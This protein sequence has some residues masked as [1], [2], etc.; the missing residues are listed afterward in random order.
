VQPTFGN[1]QDEAITEQAVELLNEKLSPISARA[2]SYSEAGADCIYPI[3][4]GDEPTIRI[5]RDRIKGPIN[6][7]ASP[8]TAPLSVLR[9][10]GINRVSFG[11]FLFRSLL[12][13]FVE[14]AEAVMAGADYSVFGEVMTDA[15]T[16]EF[17]RTETEPSL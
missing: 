3:G 1:L 12:R 16:S 2:K 14:I 6:I 13:K 15:Q 8:S 9:Q 4:S 7:L 17:L 10:I 11:P 5:L